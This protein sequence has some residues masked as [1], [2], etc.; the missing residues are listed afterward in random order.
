MM[1][2]IKYSFIT[3]HHNNPDLLLR[4]VKSIPYRDDIEIIVVDDNST[5]KPHGLPSHCRLIEIDEE[6]SR[7][8]GKARNIGLDAASGDWLLFPDSD[9]FYTIDV[10]DILDA[11][12]KERQIEMIF[13]D[14]FYNYDVVQKK[15]L[16]SVSYHNDIK[17][18]LKDSG[19][20]G[21][22]KKVKHGV[23]ASWNFAINSEFLKRINIR[24]EEVP[25]GN[26]FYFH[27]KTAMMANYVKIIP[28]RLY[29]WCHTPGSITNRK[30]TNK[31]RLQ[32]VK[33]RGEVAILLKI[34]AGAWSTIPLLHTLFLHRVLQYGIVY[35]C[36]YL[37]IKLSGN[38]PW[39]KIYLHKLILKD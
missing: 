34:E 13:F 31:E 16:S 10:L 36:K 37:K 39:S 29:Y 9:D 23:Q 1:K 20:T 18:Y 8:A 28:N 5:Q 6:H 35:A 33:E 32:Y 14:V 4:L 38:I 3:P 22:L 15:E 26:D 19:N 27:H 17:K 24:F 21:Q 25:K 30:R 12:T 2:K 7:G 11:S